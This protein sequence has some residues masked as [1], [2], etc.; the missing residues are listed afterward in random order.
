MTKAA[1]ERDLFGKPAAD[2][3]SQTAQ[4]KSVA[5]RRSQEV[6]VHQPKLPAAPKSFL[7]V[8]MEAAANPACDATKMKALLEM[9]E[10]IEDRNARKAF[11][12]AFNNLQFELPI[13]DKDGMIDHGEG[14][15]ARGNRKLKTKYST[16][17]HLMEICGPLLKKHGFTFSNTV[18]PSED[19]TKLVI[20]GYLDHVDGH[21]RTTRFPLTLDTSG[22]KNNQQGAGSSQQYGMRYNLIAMLNIVS[23]AKQDTDNDGFQQKDS[24]GDPILITEEQAV[25]LREAVEDCGVDSASFKKKF[26]IGTHELSKLPA[27][28]FENALKACANYK[29]AKSA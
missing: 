21:S 28:E 19:G 4:R 29:T 1:K 7:Q 6:V 8:I 17:P 10:R 20:V 27:S 22:G 5:Q 9:Q 12:V 25:K 3:P 13:I 26:K 23:R 24:A 16:Y 2:K 11:T 18:E 15:T 14:V